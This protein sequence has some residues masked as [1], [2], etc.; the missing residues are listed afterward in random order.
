MHQNSLEF[1]ILNSTEKIDRQKIAHYRQLAVAVEVAVE[2]DK[3]SLVVV[4][5]YQA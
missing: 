2:V 1:N 5:A 4:V 3:H